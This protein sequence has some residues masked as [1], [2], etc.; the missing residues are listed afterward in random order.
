MT[1]F[2]SW[3]GEASRLAAQAIGEAIDSVFNDAQ[4]W[5]SSKDIQLGQEWFTELRSALDSTRFAIVCLTQRNA[6]S[7]WV[8]FEAGAVAGKLQGL[9]L[10]AVQLEGE[11]ADLVDPMARFNSTRFDREG[12]QR[13]FESINLSLGSPMKPVGLKG[14][15][16]A[17]WP[18]LDAAVKAAVRSEPAYDVFL[19]VPMAA[20]DTDAQYQAFRADAMKVVTTLRD[21]CQLRV[22]CALERIASMKDFDTYGAS[23][24]DDVEALHDSANFVLIYPQRLVSSALFEAGYALARG[25]PCR[26]LV[27]KAGDLPFLMRKLPEVFTHV[28]VS[29]ADEWTTYDDLAQLLVKNAPYWFGMRYRAR[30]EK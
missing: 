21:R 13:L 25:L 4:P 29:D 5:I 20:F 14:S 1:I 11:V 18:A 16:D 28:S 30:L 22:Y 24:K 12:M 27:Q 15:F 6:A 23:A 9:K 19:S 7:P 3:S 8:M 10:V 17:V 2:L 26:F